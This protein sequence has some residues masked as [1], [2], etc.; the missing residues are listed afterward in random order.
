MPPIVISSILKAIDERVISEFPSAVRIKIVSFSFLLFF[1]LGLKT[2]L[3]NQYFYIIT[4]VGASIRAA[5]ATAVFQKV[6]RLKTS[7]R[8]KYSVRKMIVF[9]INFDKLD[10]ILFFDI[11]LIV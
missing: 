9:S 1:L 7:N 8:N 10:V 2:V 3:D 6:L 5:L 4:N 11:F